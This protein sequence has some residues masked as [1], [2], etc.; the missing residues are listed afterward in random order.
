[1]SRKQPRLKNANFAP[2]GWNQVMARAWNKPET[3]ISWQT[4]ALTFYMSKKRLQLLVVQETT[5]FP[6]KETP[7]SKWLPGL[8][9]AEEL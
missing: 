3:G 1:M 5:C 2:L 4:S 7:L 6:V 8:D 9:R